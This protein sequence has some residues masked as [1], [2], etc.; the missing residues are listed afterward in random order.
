VGAKLA[1]SI[2]N[3]MPDDMLFAAAAAGQLRDSA[4]VAAQ[5]KRLLDGS[6]GTVGLSNFNLQVYRLGTYDGITRDATAFPDFTSNAPAAMK[7]EVLQ[8]LNWMF[9]Q[10][11]GIRDFYTTPVGFVTACS[12]RSTASA[13]L[14]EPLVPHQGRSQSAPRSVR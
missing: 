3:T 13:V 7:Q 12:P 8:F 14:S 1:L 2:T 4:A 5:A 10:G 11:R 9:A 6:T